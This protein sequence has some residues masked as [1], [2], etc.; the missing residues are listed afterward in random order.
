MSSRVSSICPGLAPHAYSARLAAA[1]LHLDNL[2][3]F[4][5]EAKPSLVPLAGKTEGDGKN[6]KDG[7]AA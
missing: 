2:L 7:D 6:D 5:Q 1:L 4:G 3:G